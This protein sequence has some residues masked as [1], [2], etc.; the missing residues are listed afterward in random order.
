MF[1]DYCKNT[2]SIFIYLFTQGSR[3]TFESSGTIA[4]IGST[5]SG[6]ST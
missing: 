4:T 1:G 3:L 6:T 5:D 2:V